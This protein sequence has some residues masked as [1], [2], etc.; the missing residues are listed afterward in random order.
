MF[1]HC[2]DCGNLAFKMLTFF[3]CNVYIKRIVGADN[4][5]TQGPPYPPPHPPPPGSSLGK[6]V[7]QV[8]FSPGPTPHSPR[9]RAVAGACAY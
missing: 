2:F 9:M 4:G 5:G 1:C 8:H 3:P 7:E 6:Q